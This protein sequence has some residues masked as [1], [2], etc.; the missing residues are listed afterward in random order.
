[1]QKVNAIEAN[2]PYLMQVSSGTNS[3]KFANVSEFAA[4]NQKFY[5]AG[6]SVNGWR[7]VGTY[8][9]KSWQAGNSGIGKTYGFAANDGVNDPSIVGQFAKIGAGAYIYPMRAYLEYTGSKMRPAANGVVSSIAS[10]DTRTG[11][12]KFATDRWFDLNGRY[13]GNKNPTQKGAYYNNGKK[14]IVK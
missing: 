14:V 13:L 4:R 2:T 6:G 7:F 12:I 11:E 5:D 3:I 10:L 1:M 8:S 9:Y